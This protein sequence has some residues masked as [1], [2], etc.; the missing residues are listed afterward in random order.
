MHWHQSEMGR[1]A[2]VACVLNDLIYIPG[3]G[4][5]KAEQAYKVFFVYYPACDMESK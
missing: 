3:G 5:L 4:G 2:L 1:V